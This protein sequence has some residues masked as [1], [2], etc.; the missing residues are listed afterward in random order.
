MFGSGYD[1]IYN[2]SMFVGFMT[3]LLLMLMPWGYIYFK[4]Q[5]DIEEGLVD[6]N[7]GYDICAEET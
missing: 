6:E 3:W 7:G 2:K 4:H 1:I 5:G